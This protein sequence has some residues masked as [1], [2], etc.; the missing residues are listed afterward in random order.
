M[1]DALDLELERQVLLAA[2]VEGQVVDGRLDDAAST[3]LL[4]STPYER[5][6]VLAVTGQ[7]EA[8]LAL[9]NAFPLQ[10]RDLLL[11]DL[12]VSL[13]SAG[14]IDAAIN[15]QGRIAVT[16]VYETYE[17]IARSQGRAGQVSEA[18]ATIHSM[19][20]PTGRVP[21]LFSLWYETQDPLV[22]DALLSVLEEGQE[23]SGR[24]HLALTALSLIYPEAG[25]EVEAAMILDR[26]TNDSDRNFYISTDVEM[27]SV[28]G[29]FLKAADATA[30]I[31]VDEEGASLWRLI[32]LVEIITAM[33]ADPQ[34]P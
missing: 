9:I 23:A 22:Q 25:Y 27:F 5:S 15:A 29:Q 1:V 19:P 11:W 17:A 3:A 32:A 8:A 16:A 26:T 18:I 2:I 21:L 10:D 13:A 31:R 28:A 4:V 14:E 24:R 12:T 7:A 33:I 30:M 20:G 34:L 6:R